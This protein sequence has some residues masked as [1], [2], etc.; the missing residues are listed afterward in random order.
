MKDCCIFEANFQET[1]DLCATFGETT[2]VSTSNYDD[3]FNKP[4]LNGVTIQGEKESED[5]KLT[6]S[7]QDIEKILY[8]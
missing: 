2:K 6:L 7:V 8:L 4:I 3:L 5:Y 1:D